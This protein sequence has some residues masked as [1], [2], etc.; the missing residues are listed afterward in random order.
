MEH[1]TGEQGIGPG[2][3]ATAPAAHTLRGADT[4]DLAEAARRDQQAAE[5]QVLAAYRSMQDPKSDQQMHH[6]EL[7][8]Q[9]RQR[10]QQDELQ[11][12][13]AA[14][15]LAAQQRAAEESRQREALIASMSPQELARAMELQAQQAA[16]G[17]QVFGTQTA[18]QLAGMVQQAEL[19][20]AEQ[21]EVQR[22]MESSHEELLAHQSGDNGACPW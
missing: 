20:R 3:T 7:Q 17:A 15:Q 6:E 19:Q 13:R 11:K 8:R 10:D 21:D 18:S 22:I 16:I 5:Q 2:A 1:A 12:H 14:M 4:N 9:Q